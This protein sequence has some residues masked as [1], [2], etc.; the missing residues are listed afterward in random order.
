MHPITHSAA[1]ANTAVIPQS[2]Y[3]YEVSEQTYHVF[4]E[5][6]EQQYI[7]DDII[8]VVSAGDIDLNKQ[9]IRPQ[10]PVSI[11]AIPSII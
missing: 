7:Y 2:V 1:N 5:Y 8:C 9:Y 10:G 6:C 3:I 4:L 11:H